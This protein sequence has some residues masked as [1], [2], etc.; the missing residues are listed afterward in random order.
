MFL[1]GPIST[2]TARWVHFIVGVVAAIVAKRLGPIQ[3]N[4]LALLVIGVASGWIRMPHQECWIGCRASVVGTPVG[5]Q[6]RSRGALGA[7]ATNGEC[8]RAT[9]L[10]CYLVGTRFV[11]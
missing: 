1:P 3:R 10:V 2:W 9:I 6:L 5:G 7:M 4:S 8:E 11:D